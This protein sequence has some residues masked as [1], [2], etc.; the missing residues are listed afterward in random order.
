MGSMKEEVEWLKRETGYSW[1]EE[2]PQ[3]EQDIPYPY[4]LSRYPVTN[5]QFQPFVDDPDGYRRDD[6]WTRAGLAWRGDRS[7]PDKAGGVFDL[8]NHPVV[9]VS[10]YEA[11]AYCR[12]LTCKMQEA[13][14]KMQDWEIRLPTEA[15]WEKAARGGLEIPARPIIIDDL[16]SAI[17]NLQSANPR[18]PIPNPHPARRFPWS[19]DADPDRANYDDTR[20]GA[21]SAV[22]CFPRGESPYGCLDMSGNVWEWCATR[23]VDNYENYGRIAGRED[24][25]GDASRVLRGGSWWYLWCRVRCAWRYGYNPYWLYGDWGFRVCVSTSSPF[26]S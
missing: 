18:S 6:W 3:H 19:D 22:G 26:P 5:A 13:G 23:W 16:P 10:W 9:M 7:R 20:I 24:P 2:T 17:S 12:W 21:T 25:E 11:V 4:C 14:G 15:E 8:P 1:D